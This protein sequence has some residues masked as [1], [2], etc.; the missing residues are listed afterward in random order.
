MSTISGAPSGRGTSPSGFPRAIVA[1]AC[2]CTS[3]PGISSLSEVGTACTSW[4][5]GAL[6]PTT[7]VLPSKASGS[8]SP[9]RT[10]ENEWVGI[11]SGGP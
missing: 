5:E 7:T 9:L 2:A 8:T 11:V 1:T 3:A 4:T 10:F 6:T